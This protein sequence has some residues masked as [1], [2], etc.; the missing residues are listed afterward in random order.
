[1]TVSERT[2][3]LG[4]SSADEA[5]RAR[6]ERIVADGF[7]PKVRCTLG[8]VPF[9]ED[10]VAAFYCATDKNT[11]T[12]V[13]A[14]LFGA[15]AYFVMPVDLIPDFIAGLGYTDDATVLMAAFSA[16]RNHLTPEHRSRARRYLMRDDQ[17]DR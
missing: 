5:E 1:M 3:N 6:N 4:L 12:Y 15:L 17:P 2:S 13:R 14:V 16:V 7:W 11:P 8:R 10:A 9:T